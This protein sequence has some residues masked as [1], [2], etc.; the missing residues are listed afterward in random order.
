MVVR[1]SLYLLSVVLVPMVLSMIVN[2]DGSRVS[3]S[4]DATVNLTGVKLDGSG[5]AKKYGGTL[6]PNVTWTVFNETFGCACQLKTCIPLCC[7]PGM[8]RLPGRCEPDDSSPASLSKIKEFI[9]VVRDEEKALEQDYHLFVDD[10]C[11]ADW[12]RPSIVDIAAV[13]SNGSIYAP[14]FD[15][16]SSH[17][18]YCL[19]WDPKST[20]FIAKVCRTWV[21]VGNWEIFCAFVSAATMLVIF[22]A[23][24]VIPELKTSHGLIF[25]CF[26]ATYTFGFV[27]LWG[28]ISTIELSDHPVYF[29]IS[30]ELIRF[31][32]FSVVFWLNVMN[33]DMWRSFQ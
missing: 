7:P 15:T 25:R 2:V 1:T 17:D 23:Y 4:E 3:C 14:K 22:I 29:T 24:S 9:N 12:T 8:V 20:K 16:K 28:A 10:P 33:F 27:G 5:L 31:C 11:I 26:V 30:V 6:V 13:F 19:L 21:T 32:S 18:H